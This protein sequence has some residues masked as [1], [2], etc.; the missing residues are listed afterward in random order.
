MEPSPEYKDVTACYGKDMSERYNKLREGFKAKFGH[1]PELFARAPGRVNLIGEHI[2]YEGYGVLPMAINQDTI[3]AIA[4]GGTELVVSNL[5]GEHYPTTSFSTDPRQ[6]VNTAAHSWANY[7]VCA[8][9]GVYEL[10]EAHGTQAPEPCGLQVMIHGTVP[11][12]SGLSSSAAFVCSCFLAILAA[13]GLKVGKA[14]IAEYAA[15]AERYV[16]VTGGGMDQAI[17]M[18][19]AA[20]VAKKIEFNPVRAEDVVLPEGAVFCIGHSLA[21]SKKAEGAHKRYNLRVVECRLA[22]AM[23]AHKLGKD[24]AFCTS[25]KTLQE[26]EAVVAE[27]T[28]KSGL[29]ACADAVRANLHG[30]L[31][32]HDEIEVA[33]GKPLASLWPEGHVSLKVLEVARELGGF[34]LHDRAAHVYEEAQR[35]RDFKAVCDG[36][37]PA[38]EKLAAL[39]KLMDASHASCAGLYACSC[40]ELDELVGAAKAAGALGA[41]LTG[42]G[43]GGCTVSLVHESQVESFLASVKGAYYTT[44]LASGVAK[45]EDMENILFASK[46]SAGAAILH[47]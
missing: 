42:A 19:G 6:E 4:K 30:G 10:L 36:D 34:S 38:A 14:E 22:A 9:K 15:R 35:V 27:A 3:V 39:G 46:P 12:G 21:V 26:L 29:A 20:G 5:D 37:A 33:L 24:Q 40:P 32:T 16:G 25:V 1:A 2:D 47:V 28:G 13:H 11:L 43:W 18:M 41:R 45:E 23:L 17:S 7:F 8:Y 44:R 31:Y